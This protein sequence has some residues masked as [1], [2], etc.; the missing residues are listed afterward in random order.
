[1]AKKQQSV[2]QPCQAMV[3][4]LEQRCESKRFRCSIGDQYYEHKNSEYS[5]ERE[6]PDDH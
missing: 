1:M 2:W 5:T 4:E 6:A 3:W